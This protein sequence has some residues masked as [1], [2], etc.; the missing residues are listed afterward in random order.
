MVVIKNANSYNGKIT[1]NVNSTGAKDIYI[2][3][4]VSSSSNKTLPAGSYLVY[5]ADSKYYFRTD[6][7]I[8]GDITGSAATSNM[9]YSDVTYTVYAPSATSGAISI[10]Y[11]NGPIQ[12]ISLSGNASSV[13]ISNVPAGHS[14]H[15]IFISSSSSDERSIAIAH[16]ATTMYTPDGEAMA[17]TVPKSGSGYTEVDFI[18]VNDIIYVRGV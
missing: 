4:T 3:G 7:K 14:C 1:L 18:N 15:V 5:Y 10:N 13:S 6:G 17:L 9:T 8:T 12:V 11:N 16:N 2:N